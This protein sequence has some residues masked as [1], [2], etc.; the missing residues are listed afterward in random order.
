MKKIFL[1]L[2]TLAVVTSSVVIPSMSYAAGAASKAD[3]CQ[4]VAIISGNTNGSCDTLKS[5][6]SS[7]DGILSLVL[8]LF[9]AIVGFIAVIFIIING[10]KYVTSGG[11]SEKTNDAKNAI[12]YALIGL[13]IVALSQ[14]IVKFVL[15]KAS[16]L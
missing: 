1:T 11:S 6:G 13:V 15:H 12:I 10:L 14:I 2:I 8:N 5:S 16:A 3:T 4:G 7:I 9:S